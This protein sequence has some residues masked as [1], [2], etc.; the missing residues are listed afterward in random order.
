MCG[1]TFHFIIL[2]QKVAGEKG[3]MCDKEEEKKHICRPKETAQ[4]KAVR[5][6]VHTA[7]HNSA[8]SLPAVDRSLD[9]TKSQCPL[10][11]LSIYFVTLDQSLDCELEMDEVDDLSRLLKMASMKIGLNKSHPV[12]KFDFGSFRGHRRCIG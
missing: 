2:N 10:Y 5:E 1:V 12:G 7:F 11:D 3:A 4:L 9:L 6:F 8:S